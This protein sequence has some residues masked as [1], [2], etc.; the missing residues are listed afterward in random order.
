MKK[1]IAIATL[2]YAICSAEIALPQ[3]YF[4]KFDASSSLPDNNVRNMIMLP[5][6][7]MCIETASMLNTFDGASTLSLRYDLDKIPYTEYNGMKEIYYDS[8]DRLWIKNRDNTW[9]YDLQKEQF[10]YNVDSLAREEMA[11]TESIDNIFIVNRSQYLIYNSTQHSIYYYNDSSK[12]KIEIA[13]ADIMGNPMAISRV[14]DNLWILCDNGLL[15]QWSERSQS[16]LYIER[17][18][19][20]PNSDISKLSRFKMVADNRQQLWI[21]TDNELMCYDTRNYYKNANINTTLDKA[22]LFTAIAFDHERYV[23]VGSSKS[24]VRRIDNTTFEVEQLPH[25]A[26]VDGNNV[27]HNSDIT[28]IYADDN[29]GIW[30]A[31]ETEGL[32]YHHRDIFTF[33]SLDNS[34]ISQGRL[35][36][37][38]IKCLLNEANGT[39]L[40][41]TVNGLFRY[42]PASNSITLPYPEL[43]SE[44]CVGLYRDNRQRVW[45]GT[46][47]NGAFC[48]DRGEITHYVYDDMPDINVSYLN[49]T[50]NL[51]SIRTFYQ[52]PDQQIYVGVYGGI[53]VLNEASGQ[54]TLIG[55][56][57]NAK[58]FITRG[59]TPIDNNRLIVNGDNGLFIYNRQ[60]RSIES[61]ALQFPQRNSS[62]Y[63]LI[64]D[65]RGLI[66]IATLDGLVVYNPSTHQHRV[67]RGEDGVA[68]NKVMSVVEDW[69]GNI[70]ISTSAGVSIVKMRKEWSLEEIM[71]VNFAHFDGIKDVAF[72]P[73]SSIR[74]VD[75]RVYFGSSNGLRI[76]D[77]SRLANSSSRTKPILLNLRLYNR[78]IGVGERFLGDEILNRPLS[79]MT[80]LR[81]N[82][83][84]SFVTFEFSILNYSNPSHT[85]Y[86]YMLENFDK[87]WVVLRDVNSVAS[88]TFS[89]LHPGK[90]RFRAQ[91]S[92]DGRWWSD[93]TTQLEVVILPPWW[94]SNLAIASYL[95]LLLTTIYLVVRSI[96]KRNTKE[97]LK[98]Q[99]VEE[100]LRKEEV[101]EIKMR[102]FVNVNHELRT[103]LSLIIIPLESLLNKVG[104][105]Q[106][107]GQLE[108]IYRNAKSLLQLV[109]HLLD[110]RKIDMGREQLKAT[111]GEMTAFV[112]TTYESFCDSAKVN[113]IELIFDKDCESLTMAFDHGMMQKILN[114]LLSNAIKFTPRGGSVTLSL[115]KIERNESAPM[116]EIK[117]CDSGQGIPQKDIE[118]IFDRFFQASNNVDSKG[119]GI[120]LNLVKS[121]VEMHRGEIRVESQLGRGATFRVLIPMDIE[122][123]EVR[124]STPPT[125]EE[126][127]AEEEREIAAA[128]HTST[129]SQRHKL[130]IVEDNKEFRDYMANELS[131]LYDIEMANNG[132]Q[133]VEAIMRSAPDLVI[134]DVMMPEMD[135]LEL[136]SAIKESEEMSHIPI[137]LLTAHSSNES[138]LSSYESGADAY[139]SKPFHWGVLHARIRNLIEERKKRSGNEEGEIIEELNISKLS[140]S[141]ERFMRRALES[142]E[143]NLDNT[144][145][146]VDTMCEELSINRM[147]IYR[148]FRTTTQQTPAEFIRTVRIRR[149]A[150]WMASGK[151]RG[152]T[153]TEISERFGFNTPKYF[154]KYFKE[155]Y[156]ETPMQYIS[157]FK[158][159]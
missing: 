48:I 107:K 38:N 105:Q 23:W 124:Q 114:N 65:S 103:S 55:E 155:V 110:S 25:L 72:F 156:G 79:E 61:E 24:G 137:I 16:L 64:V 147:S 146:S 6:G 40:L 116:V 106:I 34:T 129:P 149:A 109:N 153:Q 77:P 123:C 49:S 35:S 8:H 144:E 119:T 68:N 94:S 135:G 88:A 134:S 78:P 69:S 10:I 14:D 93:E 101:E 115:A 4:R 70:W 3:S 20:A 12:Q 42:D 136:C 89:L 142:V 141:D 125:T 120:G 39:M 152:Y 118:Q 139:I 43:A 75:G 59:I 46:F 100:Q 108:G 30:I 2:L 140:P 158:D 132:R 117:V 148:R 130:L 96:I 91:S 76:A 159:R 60:T 143:R 32:L 138:R 104:D 9:I 85:Q 81:L 95:A 7:V 47:H 18:L 74:G 87:D 98:H 113:M 157:R 57:T 97:N 44:I 36:D 128:T 83:N 90:Y 131:E 66:W 27:E 126:E 51:N 29:N 21:I 41:G 102:F 52:S 82:H 1:I 54:I 50:P 80:Q 154:S 53:G 33:E 71:V 63:D 45:L 67:L 19:I 151:G 56:T 58:C 84:E 13:L 111:M 11:I 73:H 121:Y 17:Q 122:P 37:Q 5:N 26:V 92:S 62:C 31:T 15:A 28:Q 112:E 133:G 86:R 145:Y 22:D 99:L 150:R 127:R